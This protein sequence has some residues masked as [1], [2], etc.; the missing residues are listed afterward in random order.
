MRK[1][2]LTIFGIV[3]FVSVYPFDFGRTGLDANSFREFLAT[4]CMMTSRG[5]ILGNLVLFLPVGFVGMLAQRQDRDLHV[6]FSVV[7]IISIIFALILQVAQFYLP[8]RDQSLQDVI[9]NAV[10]TLAGAGLAPLLGATSHHPSS[11]AKHATLVPMMLFGAWIA[12]RLFPFV[13]SIDLQLWKDSLNP[14]LTL[15][16]RAANVLRD[17]TAWALAG[18]LLNRTHNEAGLDGY[19]LPL[20]LAILSLEI[21]IVANTVNASSLLG[22]LLGS[23]LWTGFLRRRRAPEL[24]LLAALALSILI[25]GL[26][27]FAVRSVPAE[28][29]WLP[30]RG[31][32]GGSMYLN[33]QSALE[34]LFLY[35]SFVYLCRQLGLSF[36]LT[37]FSGATVLG[38]IEMAQTRMVGHTA[39]ITDPVLLILA[40]LGIRALEKTQSQPSDES[41]ATSVASRISAG[42]SHQTVRLRSWQF[43]FLEK[44]AREAGLSLSETVNEILAHWIR[45]TGNAAAGS[46]TDEMIERLVTSTREPAAASRGNLGRAAWITLEMELSESQDALVD[47]VSR[48]L[49][50]S[51]SR[52]TRRLV[53][54]FMSSTGT[55]AQA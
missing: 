25:S 53:A 20:G 3:G 13:P 11:A 44:L 12:Y 24:W 37:A 26:M 10:G 39:E 51:R 23:A 38:L 52:A 6:R 50:I 45:Q 34:K 9:W 8:S 46:S 17:V 1:V 42:G 29:G 2:W 28:F 15:D 55:S 49:G 32:L 14:L 31:F 5:D 7:L 43:E 22:L 40:A 4:C 54:D 36:F 33:S 27:P 19:L 41:A 21:I 18:Y 47:T 16:L 35:A 30:F 48:K